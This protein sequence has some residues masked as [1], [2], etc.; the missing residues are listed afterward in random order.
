VARLRWAQSD[1][2][3]KNSL[4]LP[5]PDRQ[6]GEH[7]YRLVPRDFVAMELRLIA[8]TAYGADRSSKMNFDEYDKIDDFELNEILWRAVKGADA[9]VP[10]A[11]RGAIAYR[12]K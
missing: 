4:D 10:P 5:I 1:T 3:I 6:H 2:D 9:P 11:V 8:P 12:P 7:P